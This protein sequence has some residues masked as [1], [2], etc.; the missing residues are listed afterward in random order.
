MRRTGILLL[1]RLIVGRNNRWIVSGI[2]SNGTFE[3]GSIHGDITKLEE[4][5]EALREFFLSKPRYARHMEDP[6]ETSLRN[7]D[8]H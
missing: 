5:A 7:R 1:D 6:N 2:L 4:L 3:V 8:L